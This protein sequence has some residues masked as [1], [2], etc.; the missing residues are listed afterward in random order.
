MSDNKSELR[1]RMYCFVLYN[2]SPIQQGIQAAHAIVEFAQIYSQAPEYKRWAEIDKT[3][4]ILNGGSSITLY[5]HFKYLDENQIIYPVPFYE[6]E[7]FNGMTAF[8]F[9]ADERV[10]DREKYPD[11]FSLPSF[12]P[13]FG[14]S[15]VQLAPA[16]HR[17][18][19]MEE[20]K[21]RIGGEKNF[22]LKEFLSRFKLA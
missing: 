1:Q 8:C 5:D 10:W 20:F 4:I 15:D 2:I 18:F 9:L 22:L 19:N 13:I 17:V 12:T 11:S 16:I 6:P 7:L 3:I 14:I 21:E